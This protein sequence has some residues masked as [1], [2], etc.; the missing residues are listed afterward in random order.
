[1]AWQA[2]D[3]I[4]RQEFDVPPSDLENDAA[5]AL[6]EAGMLEVID[7]AEGVS[8]VAL[9][10]DPGDPE[11][12]ALLAASY[13][14]SDTLLEAQVLK[15]LDGLIGYYESDPVLAALLEFVPVKRAKEADE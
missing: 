6:E 2:D 3:G 1:M 10:V 9:S 12:L 11:Q 14:F 15:M 4:L 13:T 7:R 5:L 8:G